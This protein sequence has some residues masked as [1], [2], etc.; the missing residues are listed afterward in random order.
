[1]RTQ[2]VKQKTH[3]QRMV[4]HLFQ[5]GC[6]I[7]L[8]QVCDF[9]IKILN[10]YA[11]WQRIARISKIISKMVTIENNNETHSNFLNW[12]Q[13]HT[14]SETIKGYWLV[15]VCDS[16]EKEKSRQ[17]MKLNVMQSRAKFL[18]REI[19]ITQ[20]MGDSQFLLFICFIARINVRCVYC[21]KGW[22]FPLS[23]KQFNF[24]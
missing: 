6:K 15:S 5:F 23:T 13:N 22:M 12:V 7:H 17:T 14:C 20:T 9:L 1:M 11:F 19:S 16:S 3:K 21:M 10:E 2:N 18:P 8:N 4:W 24:D